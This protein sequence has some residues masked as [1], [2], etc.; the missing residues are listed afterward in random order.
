MKV[1]KRRVQ[2]YGYFHNYK[3]ENATT[4]APTPPRLIEYYGNYFHKAGIIGS[5]PEQFII[6]EYREYLLMLILRT[7]DQ[8]LLEYVLVL[9]LS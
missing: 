7:T 9:T 4:I 1:L 2:H 3:S 5:N 8:L 6:N